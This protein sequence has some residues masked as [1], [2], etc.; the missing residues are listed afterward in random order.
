MKKVTR[1]FLIS[2]LVLGLGAFCPACGDNEEPKQDAKTDTDTKTDAGSD[3]ESDSDSDSDSD[4]RCENPVFTGENCDVCDYTKAYGEHCTAYGSVTDQNDNTYKTAII[5][6]KE[7]MAENLKATKDL[8]GNNVTCY[9]NTKGDADFVKKYGCLYVWADANKVCPSG[10]RLPTKDDFDQ[11]FT[12]YELQDNSTS[13]RNSTWA[14]GSNS[15]GFGALPA[16]GVYEVG[17]E[18]EYSE[19]NNFATFWSATC[20]SDQ[21]TCTASPMSEDVDAFNFKVSDD[22]SMVGSDHLNR[23]FSVRC[24]KDLQLK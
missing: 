23:A 16:G 12:A 7:W 14:N 17:T 15:T 21:A 20:G 19:L 1:N 13:I 24:I 4:T 22:G 6:S 10:W 5:N 8:N 18:Y 2:S 11:L 3:A 9:V